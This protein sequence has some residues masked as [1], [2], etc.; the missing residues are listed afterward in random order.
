M[1]KKDGVWMNGRIGSRQIKVGLEQTVVKSYDKK[2]G[3]WANGRIVSNL[4]K[5]KMKVHW[6][7]E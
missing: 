4:S 7:V 6:T 5:K 1:T 2:D 3:V